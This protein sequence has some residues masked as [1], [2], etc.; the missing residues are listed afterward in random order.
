MDKCNGMIFSFVGRNYSIMRDLILF[1][2]LI[3]GTYLCSVGFSIVVFRMF[4]PLK[5]RE[6]EESRLTL[7]YSKSKMAQSSTKNKVHVL[8]VS[9]RR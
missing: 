2:T 8:S 4:F 5:A 3:A 9:S 1:I 7:T 6:T